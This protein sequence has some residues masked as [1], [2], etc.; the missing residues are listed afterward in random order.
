MN[1]LAWLHLVNSCVRWIAN[2]LDQQKQREEIVKKIA[3][4]SI[5]VVGL[6]AAGF[7]FAHG[8][9]MG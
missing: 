3:I 6:A 9:G 4:A 8:N 7:A 2:R 5:L 1:H